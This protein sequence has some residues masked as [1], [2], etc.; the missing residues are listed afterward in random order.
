M[1]NPFL[2]LIEK[3]FKWSEALIV[4]RGYRSEYNLTDSLKEEWRWSLRQ[5]GWKGSIYYL[6][7]DSSNDSFINT[8]R[9]VQHW[10]QIKDR[11]N[12]V[13]NLYLPGL[14][15]YIPDKSVSLIGYS[16]GAHV[17]YSAMKVWPISL[18]PLNNAILIGGAISRNKEWEEITPSLGG[19][20]INVYN[21]HDTT[22]S[23]AYR[24]GELLFSSSPCGLKPIK[25]FHPKI[26][27]INATAFAGWSHSELD[28][29]RAIRQIVGQQVWGC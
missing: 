4:I 8:I 25:R 16:L 18:K 1:N 12:C 9:N 24:G 22:L 27:N 20:L 26:T 19:Q 7:W 15:S 2:T 3:S 10:Q 5:A 11:A 23:G 21:S 29:L 6:W 13:G 28:Y 14:V 17:I